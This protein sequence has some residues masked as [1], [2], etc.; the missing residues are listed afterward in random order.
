MRGTEWLGVVYP[1]LLGWHAAAA[2]SASFKR[3]HRSDRVHGSGDNSLLHN[4]RAQGEWPE[5]E[6]QRCVAYPDS[7]CE[8]EVVELK[9]QS[10]SRLQR[11]P[12]SVFLMV[13]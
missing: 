11:R 1:M 4:A 3:D 13:V 8:K 10:N 9:A 2:K 6:V 12:R 7:I 5:G